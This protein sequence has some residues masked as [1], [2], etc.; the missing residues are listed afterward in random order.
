MKPELSFHP[1]S[2]QEGAKRE[3]LITNGLGGYASST[4]LGANTRSYHGLLVAALNPP[5]ERTLLLSSL[6][7]ELISE[8][9]HHHLACHQ[10]PGTIY[11][12]GFR[13]LEEF[14]QNPIPTFLYKTEDG[15]VVEKRV[16]MVQ[17]ENTIVVNYRV[18][19]RG[20][21]KVV[22]LVNCR[23]FHVASRAPSIDQSALELEGGGSGVRLRSWCDFVLVSDKARY[24]Q[25]ELVYNNLEYE[26]ER[27]RGLL[28]REDSFSPGRFEI[29]VDGHISFN[30]VASID[31]NS[32]EGAEE[33]MS[34]EEERVKGLLGDRRRDPRFG[35]LAVGADQFLVRRGEGK[36][37]IAGYHWFN[38]WGR[39]A[40]ISLPG[41][42]LT[43]RRFDEARDVLTTFAGAMKDGLLPNDFGA[44]GYNTIDA[45]LWFF[46]AV[47]KYWAYSGDTGLVRELFP[48]LKAIVDRYSRETPGSFSDLD[49]L[50]VSKPGLTWMDAKV[51]GEFVTPRA[52]KACE[53]NA[54]WYNALKVME[55]FSEELGAEWDGSLAEKIRESYEKFWNSEYG[56][57][58]DLIDEIDA[59][60]RP[61]QVIAASLPFTPLEA[62][63]IKGIVD[64]ATE[65]LLTPYGLRTLS[66]KDPAYIGRYEGGPAERDRAYHQGTVWP[67]LIGPYITASLKASRGSKKSRDEA[68][69]L[70][71]PLMDLEDQMG[72]GTICEV[73]DGDEPHRPGGCI[74]QAWSVGEVMRAWSEDVMG[75]AKRLKRGGV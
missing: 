33:L 41:L 45:A 24:V 27:Q 46:E 34:R 2:Y 39:D 65:E 19:G 67:W 1:K 8:S 73:F 75:G 56:C 14:R 57:L 72:V 66:P 29:E 61:N 26:V 51:G 6:D 70:L 44:Q 68:R 22:P 49:G 21:F 59:A 35:R 31:R 42:L 16:F 17:G 3:W 37:I 50:I 71:R 10:Y 53:I 30:V 5:T 4:I 69:E 11:P 47:Y 25:E 48:S 62:D 23:S 74:S 55:V 63:Q 28:W 12:Q 18:E 54:L 64:L 60:I 7:E 43:T 32:P 15:T 13:H 40:M 9:G 52:G 58:F 20:L 36:S 38:D